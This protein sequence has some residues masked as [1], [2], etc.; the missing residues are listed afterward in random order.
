MDAI[1]DELRGSFEEIKNI[2][3]DVWTEFNSN[4]FLMQ[5]NEM[6]NYI[7]RMKKQAKNREHW[8]IW[9]KP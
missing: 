8:S 1:M 9:T 5:L 7:A 6:T 2:P 4:N 3:D